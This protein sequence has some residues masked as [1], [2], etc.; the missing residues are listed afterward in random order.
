MFPKALADAWFMI[1]TMQLIFLTRKSFTGFDNF[2]SMSRH[3]SHEVSSLTRGSREG[4]ARWRQSTHEQPE[5][6]TLLRAIKKR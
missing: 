2:F 3:E 6:D 5:C 1:L 4:I